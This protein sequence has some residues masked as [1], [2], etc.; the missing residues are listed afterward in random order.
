M[1]DGARVAETRDGLRV[2]RRGEWSCVTNDNWE[3]L[4]ALFN[5][6]L[7]Q[8]ADQRHEWLIEHAGGDEMLA[9]E[10][11]ALVLAHETADGFLETPVAIDPAAFTGIE[12]SEAVPASDRTKS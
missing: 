8:P 2:G 6:A 11:A 4:K 9:R 1:D 12:E 3:R 7:D 10:A 5:G